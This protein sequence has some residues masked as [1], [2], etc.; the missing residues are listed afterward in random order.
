[1]KTVETI[2]TGKNFI[3]VSVGKLNEIKNYVLPMGDIE[4]PGKVFVGQALQATGS[5]LSFQVLVPN[6]DSG[7]LHTHKTHEELYF[8]LKGEGEYQVDGE[9]FSV[10]E[11]S[12]IRVA[13]NGKRALKNTG[14]DEMLMLCIQYKAN[15]FA[16]NDSPAGDG[17]ILN[18]TLTW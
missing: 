3:A 11:G 14:K 10:S 2:K 6:Q 12:I 5:E 4:I 17:V 13:P 7:F 18:D 16:E 15:S 8:I 1:M 9:I